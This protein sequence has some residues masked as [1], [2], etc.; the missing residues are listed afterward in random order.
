MTDATS[1]S[2]KRC[3]IVRKNRKKPAST[4][5][6]QKDCHRSQYY[7]TKGHEHLGESRNILQEQSPFV[8]PPCSLM[9]S[10]FQYW[11]A[12]KRTSDKERRM[13]VLKTKDSHDLLRRLRVDV[14][15][16]VLEAKK[17]KDLEEAIAITD[18]D[19]QYFSELDD[20]LVRE[21]FSLRNYIEDTREILKARLL[22]G[23][24]MDDCIRIDQQFV[25]EQKR[26]DQIRRRYRQYVNGFE[27]FLSKDHEE[28]MAILQ[29]AEDEMKKT[30]QITERRNKLSTE[31]GKVRLQVYHWEESWR[32]VKMCQ[33]F[34]Y[35]V[36]P[37]AWRADYDWIHRTDS[38]ESI[39]HHADDLFGRYRMVE[40][41]ASLDV[42]IG[43][44]ALYLFFD[45]KIVR[46]VEKS[47]ICIREC[48]TVEGT[49]KKEVILHEKIYIRKE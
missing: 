44:F 6:F 18:I 36:S 42:L 26:L 46:F 43:D 3:Q 48:P 39:L 34:L 20:R 31:Y 25:E 29:L 5:K 9:F 13:G 14:D 49:I 45:Q 15:I 37:I 8:Y 38:G 16:E 30:R 32:M 19:P 21:K 47:T 33:R 4:K 22:V 10:Y 17:H 28:S 27:E 7:F 12:K 24:E 1:R 41:V 40:E 11:K 23:Q 2:S 35:Q